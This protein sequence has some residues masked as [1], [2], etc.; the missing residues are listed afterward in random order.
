MST[1]SLIIL[2]VES[3]RRDYLLIQALVSKTQGDSFDVQWAHEKEQANAALT[4]RK[5]LTDATFL[6]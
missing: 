2:L 6:E 3:S 5:G 4:V 1:D